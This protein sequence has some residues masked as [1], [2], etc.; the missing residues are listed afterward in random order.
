MNE[1]SQPNTSQSSSESQSAS[2]NNLD[3]L[4]AKRH[5][6]V[7]R[8][9]FALFTLVIGALA[10]AAVWL[11]LFLLNHGINLIWDFIPNTAFASI[12]T[13]WWP[14]VICSLGGILVG[15]FER[16][17]G[18]YPESLRTVMADVKKT[19]RYE[20]KH[21]GATA[22]GAL[23]PLLFGG[24]IGPEA[25]LTGV[26]AGLCTWIG[27]RL[28][29][30]GNEF[31]ELSSFGT[32]AVLSAIFSAPLFGLAAPILGSCD[33][34]LP[35]T[36]LKFL[37]LAKAIL[38]L[39]VAA[40]AFGIVLLLRS[41]FGGG[42]G[43]PHFHDISIGWHEVALII[44]LAFAG[45]AI[46]LLFHL[47]DKLAH[48]L[49]Q[50]IGRRPVFKALLAGLIL[51]A[52]GTAFPLVMFAGETQADLLEHSWMAMGAGVLIITA[53][54]KI[55]MTP[56][57]LRL[58]WR[59]GHFFP[60]IFAGICL[61]YGFALITGAD[62]VSCLCICSAAVMGGIMRQPI[63]TVLLLFLLFPIRA[64][65]LMLAAAFIGSALVSFATKLF[66]HLTHNTH[67]AYSSQDA[68]VTEP[69]RH[70]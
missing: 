29:F 20:Y 35:N 5:P 26:I 7:N 54:L 25:G 37:K 59:G 51:G 60:T 70:S 57:C 50:K 11:F 38:Y 69:T 28:K 40:G 64:F 22:G 55:F 42:E 17:F 16:K 66:N 61:G 48:T 6:I 2:C 19:G 10:G 63:M 14:L 23:L 32:T 8:V 33:Q 53:V 65:L 9:I 67:N 34:L 1:S 52:L 15:L 58:G 24:S 62:P 47:F 31:R 46:G 36:K 49:A 27:D 43:L 44:P 30:L 41:L 68:Y 4:R 21:I 56:F 18:P 12:N 13:W 45:G 3:P 39:L